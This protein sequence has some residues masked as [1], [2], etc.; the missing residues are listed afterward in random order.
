MLKSNI[1]FAIVLGLCA[2]FGIIS[3]VYVDVN[4]LTALSIKY[5]LEN[6]SVYTEF[7]ISHKQITNLII[8]LLT[9]IAAIIL[10]SFL[11]YGGIKHKMLSILMPLFTGLIILLSMIIIILSILT[12]LKKMKTS[13][14]NY[15]NADY[16]STIFEVTFVMS[17]P[18][19]CGILGMLLSPSLIVMIKSIN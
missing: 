6:T 10:L 16:N 1:Y 4:K 17:I 11:N 2:I 19:I 7:L 5:P 3:L 15:Y 18:L 8:A 12:G 14:D 9:F 13:H